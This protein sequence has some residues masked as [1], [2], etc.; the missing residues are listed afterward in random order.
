VAP[1]RAALCCSTA[2][3]CSTAQSRPLT[4]IA[5]T[6]RRPPTT[7][8][9][10]TPPRSSSSS[11]ERRR[12]SCTA[13]RCA[14]ICRIKARSRLLQSSC[15]SMSSAR[16]DDDESRLLCVVTS[17]DSLKRMCSVLSWCARA[18]ALRRGNASLSS[19]NA[20]DVSQRAAAAHAQVDHRR[21]A[22]ER[23]RRQ[24]A[25]QAPRRR[26]R[27]APRR[28]VV[29]RLR[30]FAARTGAVHARSLSVPEQPELNERQRF[31]SMNEYEQQRLENIRRNEQ[32]LSSLGLD[33]NL[34][35]RAPRVP[36]PKHILTEEEKLA[37]IPQPRSKIVIFRTPLFFFFFFFLLLFC[38]S[39]LTNE[40]ACSLVL[41]NWLPNRKASSTRTN[42]CDGF[43]HRRHRL[44][45]ELVAVAERCAK[46]TKRYSKAMTTTKKKKTLK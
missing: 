30:R 38:N 44:A 36:K 19:A 45:K 26:D 42:I 29:R 1:A 28:H 40:N 8:A 41:Q 46:T 34:M 33:K 31:H 10:C 15:C 43:A 3:R 32:Y 23:R 5:T 25:R 13:S 22:V 37:R 39:S 27:A 20:A 24:G 6:R 12:S 9:P 16:S 2:H 14:I 4:P 21:H 17:N 11:S 18:V 35:K 7:Y